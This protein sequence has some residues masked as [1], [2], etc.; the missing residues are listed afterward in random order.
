MHLILYSGLFSWVEIFVKCWIQ[1]SELSFVVLIFVTLV[2]LVAG[3]QSSIDHNARES[4]QL[5][6]E[7]PVKLSRTLS[8]GCSHAGKL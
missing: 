7:D 1:S 8:M 6:I 4:G 5:E 2:P 3:V